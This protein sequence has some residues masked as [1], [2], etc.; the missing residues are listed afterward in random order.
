MGDADARPGRGR[1]QGRGRE[2]GRGRGR[3]QGLGAG[4][5]GGAA[6]CVGALLLG[7]V[8]AAGPGRTVAGSLWGGGGAKAWEGSVATSLGTGAAGAEPLRAW[9]AGRGGAGAGPLRVLVEGFAPWCPHCQHFRPE[10]EKVA[11]VFNGADGA[12]AGV[13]VAHM[14]CTKHH[15]ACQRLGV[16]FFPALF[17]CTP[18][19]LDRYLTDPKSQHSK[20]TKLRGETTPAE[21]CIYVDAPRTA[22]FTLDWVNA[23]LGAAYTLTGRAADAKGPPA[24]KALT[25]S[26]SSPG[27]AAAAGP[28]GAAGARGG[29]PGVADLGDMELAAE[30]SVVLI[31]EAREHEGDPQALQGW[32]RLIA[33]SHPSPKCRAGAASL[34]RDSSFHDRNAIPQIVRRAEIGELCPAG[35]RPGGIHGRPAQHHAVSFDGAQWGACKGMEPGTRGFTCGLW[36]AFHALS[37][38]YATAAG[39]DRGQGGAELLHQVK[40]FVEH[41]FTCEVCRTHFLEMAAEDDFRE[42]ETPRQAALWLWRAHNV[43]N[44]RLRLEEAEGAAAAEGSGAP[45]RT[46]SNPLKVQ[47]PT[48]D[49]CPE[50]FNLSGGHMESAV[51][52]FLQ[53]FYGAW[54]VPPSELRAR[55]TETQRGNQALAGG[56][57]GRLGRVG[58]HGRTV[59]GLSSAWT[60]AG[61]A[62]TCA[63]VWLAK[64]KV[65]R[66]REVKAEL[67]YNV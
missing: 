66:R 8:G 57:G 48:R 54:P 34:L 32:L 41:F 53:Q 24:N 26:D 38:N 20:S 15:S 2:R 9:V 60:L 27:A 5:R 47:F 56:M 3:G 42:A 13:L 67:G 39:P 51:F 21:D 6:G 7:A 58:G 61:L 28:N 65:M 29:S 12:K 64:G 49:Q 44:A 19:A 25:G 30:L 52:S 55:T 18:E 50:C 35:G 16:E 63:V 23:R 33:G 40:G 14:D 46:S 11:Q 59:E 4:G 36:M 62:L 10:Y 17:W 37:V 45:A 22:K 43:V 31:G 1:G